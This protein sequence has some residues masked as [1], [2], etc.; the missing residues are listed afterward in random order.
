MAST[1]KVS[2]LAANLQENLTEYS[3][4]FAQKLVG[5]GDLLPHIT[6]IPGVQ[7]KVPLVG[8]TTSDPLQVG[9]RG[10]WAPKSDVSNFTDRQLEVKDVEIAADFK[11]AEIESAWRSHL[12]KLVGDRSG[13]Y[14]VPFEE[15]IMMKLAEAAVDNLR[16]K[17]IFKGDFTAA[18]TTSTDLFDGFLKIIADEITATNLTPV[19]GAAITASNAVDQIEAVVASVGSEYWQD[20]LVCV[21]APE[22]A[23][24]YAQDYRASFGALPYNTEFQKTM[25]D[26]TNIELVPE[27]GM[28]GSDRIII[29]KRGNLALGVDAL[30]GLND[31]FVQQNRFDLE[32]GAKMKGG[33][34]IAR[35]DEVWVNDQA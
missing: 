8:L 22:N 11:E 35:L 4:I 7:D 17:A 32:F 12:G 23:R 13:K 18:G 24:F 25:I 30:D 31:M 15:L 27:I 33:V 9:N 29:A 14:D 34:Q 26:G 20:D 2:D 16:R 10:S 3:E 28:A 19:A 21:V 5:L 1:I 6:V